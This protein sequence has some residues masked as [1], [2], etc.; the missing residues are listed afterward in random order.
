ADR[1]EG[2]RL[3][4]DGLV[5]N[6]IHPEFGGE[7]PDGLRDRSRALADGREASGDPDSAR[8]LGELYANLADFVELATRE[9]RHL[10]GLEWSVGAVP[11][12][13]VPMLGVE[14]CDIASLSEVGRYLLGAA[15]GG[16]TAAG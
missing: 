1:L 3:R 16:A 5:V 14:V 4:V 12:V 8:R 2:A 9:R 11:V 15:S 7:E 13:R 10:E 6:R